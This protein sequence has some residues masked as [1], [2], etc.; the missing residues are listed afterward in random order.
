MFKYAQL[1]ITGKVIGVSSLSGEVI[2]D[3]LIRIED[4]FSPWGKRYD[5][6]A[7]SWIDLPPIDPPPGEPPSE[8][9]VQVDPQP[10]LED[11]IDEVAEIA[12]ATML[13]ITELYERGVI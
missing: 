9:P 1:D 2:A 11:K 8:E 3:D 5:K 6:E 7:N 4:G 13:A 12:M 10:T